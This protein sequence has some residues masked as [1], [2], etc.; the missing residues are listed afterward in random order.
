M[1]RASSN[2]WG[3]LYGGG[4]FE[5]KGLKSVVAPGNSGGFTVFDKF[6]N[7]PS[8][9][10]IYAI[11]SDPSTADFGG[12]PII[13]PAKGT[14]IENNG[15]VPVVVPVQARFTINENACELYQNY[16]KKYDSLNF[17]G[18]DDPS[19]PGGWAQFL[20]LQM[21]QV[22]TTAIR[23]QLAGASYVDLYTNFSKYPEIQAN[24]SEALTNAL[25][26]S[27][28]GQFFCGPSYQFDGEADGELEAC[29]PIEIVIK[30]IQPEDPQF[31]N[32]LKTIVANQEAQV[33]ISSDRDK[34]IA[35]ANAERDKS[36]AQSEADKD[37]ALAATEANRETELA[38]TAANKEVQLAKAIADVE[39]AR[40]F[41]EVVAVETANA[42]EKKKVETAFCER[43]A[44]TG[45]NCA[46]YYKYQNYSPT[47]VLAED[48]MPLYTLPGG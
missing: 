38:A 44:A 7:I 37:K 31:L 25:N 40:A 4:P 48:S 43:L 12:Q 1:N 21:N 10:R 28:G 32:N 18:T 39:I 13:V 42:L 41:A 14:D 16:L 5:S 45:V 17:N 9:D 3:C 30:T 26:A 24:V 8:D 35:Q 22:L 6:I 33:V 46:E 47:V 15:I 34:A 29:P 11:D 23:S 20:N 36:V 19:N 2:E 27:L